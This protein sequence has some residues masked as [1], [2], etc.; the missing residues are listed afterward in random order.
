MMIGAVVAWFLCGAAV[1]GT[2]PEEIFRQASLSFEAGEM[3]AAENGFSELRRDFPKHQLYW[4]S[5][6]MWARCARDPGEAE[7]RFVAV[8]EKSP[9]DIKAECEIE[10]AHLDLIQDKYDD[11]EKAYADWL[12]GRDQDERAESAR[13]FRG[14][15]L[16]ELGREG[17]AAGLLD[18]LFR[19]GKQPAW[20]AESGLVL[21]GIKFGAGD[22]SGARSIY[23][24]MSGA[25]WA[26]ESRPQALLGSARTAPTA[27]ERAKLLKDLLKDYPDA[28]ES[29]E[30]AAMLGGKK[31]GKGRFGVQI[32]AFSR[33]SN[34]VVMKA[35]WARKGKRAAILSRKMGSLSLYAVLLG[36]FETREAAEQ[37]VATVKAQ[38][39]RAIVTPY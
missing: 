33:K 9:P 26:R 27:G 16:K 10:L 23:V 4:F 24:E 5:G 34:A 35:D 20:R 39:A 32:G 11:A 28:D 17:E 31:K 7:K 37:E 15:C 3:E 29:A 36:P 18:G 13:F 6:L 19:E 12:V 2:P 30:A 1:A 21:A 38:G 22:I 8:M 25:E 14:W